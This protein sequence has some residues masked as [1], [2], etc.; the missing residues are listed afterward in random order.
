[1]S[2]PMA[3]PSHS[4]KKKNNVNDRIV[5]TGWVVMAI[6]SNG[7]SVV[8]RNFL[9]ILSWCYVWTDFRLLRSYWWLFGSFTWLSMLEW[10][11]ESALVRSLKRSGIRW[12]RPVL[13][14]SAGHDWPLHH[15]LQVVTPLKRS[16]LGIQAPAL[17]SF[18]VSTNQKAAL[19][20]IQNCRVTWTTIRRRKLHHHRLT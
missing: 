11:A 15:R 20:R 10:C 18:L 19:K 8:I 13:S 2:L 9:S 3:A 1:M 16:C 7:S 5:L 6:I 12:T 17:R 14:L 4:A